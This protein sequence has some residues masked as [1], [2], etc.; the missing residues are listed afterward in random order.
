[1]RLLKRISVFERT[2]ALSAVGFIAVFGIIV[3]I[4]DNVGVQVAR[5]GP[6]QVGT[7]TSFVSV[8]FDEVM[9]RSSVEERFSIEPEIEG[10]FSW[11]GSRLIFRPA[12]RLTP[13]TNYSVTVGEGAQSEA[14]RELLEEF[15]FQFRVRGARVAYLKT[16]EDGIK[17]NIWVADPSG[18]E[19]P[20]RLTS[21]ELGIIYFDVSPDG[22]KIAFRESSG[23]GASAGPQPIRVLDIASGQ[24]TQVT[25]LEDSELS[26]PTWNH[27]G[28]K[29]AYTR[30]DSAARVPGVDPTLIGGSIPRVWVLDLSQDPP[31]N[32]RLLPPDTGTS[33]SPHWS[34]TEDVLVVGGDP[35]TR[36]DGRKLTVV[37][38]T[39][40]R[41]FHVDANLD[42]SVTFSSDGQSFMTLDRTEPDFRSPT[43]M[44][45]VDVESEQIEPA[46]S[47]VDATSVRDID[48]EWQPGQN[49]IAVLRGSING[50][51]GRTE[52]LYIVD[53]ETGETT[54]VIVTIVYDI[55]GASWSPSGNLLAIDRFERFTPDGSAAENS[56]RDIVIFDPLT[57][58]ITELDSNASEPQ[59]IP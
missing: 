40:D 49:N 52:D 6:E 28:T 43:Q 13:E 45:K 36:Q 34:P 47:F 27:D 21:S 22:R 42:Q 39:E 10:E 56:V 31:T 17:K 8:Q 7:S 19:S 26:E 57:G 59:W 14:G 50:V 29:I 44:W 1:M 9:D 12:I 48:L 20:Q 18:N 58:E 23:P 37:D 32:T 5:F 54:P 46:R 24:L 51:H 2:M 15:N 3:S 25:F 38:L 11:N 55:H 35:L 53:Y 33:H 30:I 16:E 41:T 4:G